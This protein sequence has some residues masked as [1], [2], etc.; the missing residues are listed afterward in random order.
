MRLVDR[1]GATR[2]CS[3]DFAR[4]NVPGWEWERFYEQVLEPLVRDEPAQYQRYDWNEDRLGEWETIKP[5]GIVVAEG[6]SITRRKLGDPG[7]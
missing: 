2:V 3:D 5:G 7:I 6:V 1:V 4:P